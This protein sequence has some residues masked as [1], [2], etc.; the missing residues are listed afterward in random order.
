MKGTG[1]GGAPH[2]RPDFRNKEVAVK[3]NLPYMMLKTRFPSLFAST[4]LGTK[5]VKITSNKSPCVREASARTN[6]FPK[7]TREGG[8]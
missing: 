3:S 1:T 6:F 8:K 5:T 7:D 2:W 4:S